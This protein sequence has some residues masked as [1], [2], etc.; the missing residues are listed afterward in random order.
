MKTRY[1]SA[2]SFKIIHYALLTE[3]GQ[4]EANKL[5]E[6]IGVREQD[7]NKTDIKL[8]VDL[9]YSAWQFAMSQADNQLLG[10]NAGGKLNP[11][12]LGVLGYAILNSATI[13]E[14]WELTLRANPFGNESVRHD[15]EFID[16][17]IYFYLRTRRPIEQVRPWV[18]MNIVGWK[19]MFNHLTNF[20]YQEDSP[21]E[22]VCFKSQPSGPIEEYQRALGCEVMFNQPDNYFVFDAK[23]ANY[24]VHCADR[25]ELHFY[26]ERLGLTSGDVSLSERTRVYV[27]RNL[28]H[29]GL[30]SLKNVAEHFHLSVSTYKR[31]LADEGTNYSILC[32]DLRKNMSKDLLIST[33][34][35]ASDISFILGYDKPASFF[36]AFKK[37]EEFTPIEYRL[38]N[39]RN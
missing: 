24:P 29:G 25:S 5:L 14:A 26:L 30:P 32:S 37:W 4:E 39:K 10:L 38:K 19:S 23:F 20:Q 36:K 27:K 33:D 13:S 9:Y 7:L 28:P 15:I 12:L 2:L 31:H 35:K 18:E 34:L 21:Y 6:Y 1:A 11:S 17:K 22:L 8:S 3:C 16:G